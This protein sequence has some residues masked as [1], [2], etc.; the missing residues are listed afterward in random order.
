M[1]M[2]SKEIFFFKQT[3]IWLIVIAFLFLLGL[4]LIESSGDPRLIVNDSNNNST[5]TIVF[6]VSEFI[7]VAG[8]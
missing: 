7:A 4:F 5:N 2:I 8:R 3:L 6:I 1:M